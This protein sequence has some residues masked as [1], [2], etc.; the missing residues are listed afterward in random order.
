MGDRLETE[1][2]IAVD[3]CVDTPDAWPVWPDWERQ[4]VVRSKGVQGFPYRIVYF[5]NGDLMTVVAVAHTKRRPGYWR[6]RV[7]R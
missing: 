2:L 4:P 5:V 1:V 3:Q 6:D 7:S